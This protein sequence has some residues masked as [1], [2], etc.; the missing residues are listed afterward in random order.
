MLSSSITK[1]IPIPSSPARSNARKSSCAS[2]SYLDAP[3]RPTS[4]LNYPAL[5]LNFYPSSLL[6]TSAP[7]LLCLISGAFSTL[8]LTKWVPAIWWWTSSLSKPKSPPR[9]NKLN[10]LLTSL[11]KKLTLRLRSTPSLSRTHKISL[12]TSLKSLTKISQSSLRNTP[13]PKS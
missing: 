3:D 1:M 7:G 5:L 9:W 8:F 2:L 13:L 12:T 10:K 11:P 4:S 6:N